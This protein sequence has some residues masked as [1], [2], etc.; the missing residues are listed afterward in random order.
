MADKRDYYE[1]LGVD[2][3]ASQDEIKK[4]Y[5]K[6]AKKYHPDLNPGDKAKEAEEKFKEASE[7]YEVLSDADKKSKYDQFGHAGVDPNFGAGGFG[8]GYGGFGGGFE[9]IFDSF[10]GGGFGGSSRRNSNAPRKG[11]DIKVI[12]NLDFKEAC[13]GKEVE[14]SVNRTERCEECSGTGSAKGTSPVRCGTCG[15]TGQVTSVQNTPFGAFQSSRPCNACGGKGTR[16]TTPCSKCH[17]SGEMRKTKKITVKIPAG[18][19]DGQMVSVSGQGNAGKNG[20]PNGDLLVAVRIKPHDFFTRQGFDVVCDLPIT[21]EEATLGAEVEVPTVDGTVSYEI[22]EGTQAGTVF[23]LR[24]QG[25]TKLHGNGAR[26][27]QYV[28]VNIE[29]P[30]NLNDKQKALLK[31]FA[32]SVTPSNYAK[33]KKFIDKIKEWMK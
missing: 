25:I 26:G 6:L 21:F 8:G 24:G 15:G 28:K 33:K 1:V 5:R 31:Q 20:G 7:A 32:D 3:S 30:K 18:I 23:R 11:S 29:I 17:G 19:D 13:F 2:K 14:V 27:D 16:I 9:D 12:V 22:P 4:A 10:F